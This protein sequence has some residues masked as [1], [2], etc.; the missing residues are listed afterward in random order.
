MIE[1]ENWI[2]QLNRKQ[3]EAFRHLFEKFY[4]YLVLY[5]MKW[6]ERQEIAE[7]IV[8]ELFVQLWEH[9][10]T[11]SSY[12]GLKNFLYNSVKN[13]SFD[14]L[15]HQ[16]VEGKYISYSL[17]HSEK[18]EEPD[19]EIMKSEIYRKLY[20]T[21]EELPK[22]CREVFKYHLEGKKNTEIATLLHISESTVKKQKQQAIKYIS[23]RLGDIPALLSLL[24]L[25]YL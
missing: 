22:R 8:Q 1:P 16:K 5:A 24:N 3:V 6:V 4:R 7:D 2:E 17:N 19:L 10:T 25:L 13:A 9:H 12:Y 21:I 14:Y 20:L 15:K 18:G 11:Y 23:K